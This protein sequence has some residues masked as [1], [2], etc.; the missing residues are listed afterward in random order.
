[1]STSL[2]APES[3]PS[4]AKQANSPKNRLYSL[5]ILRGF[6]M[7]W[8]MGG[9]EFVV[10]FFRLFSPEMAEFFAVQFEHVA[11]NGFHFYD[12]IFP[13]FVFMAG[14]SIPFSVSNRVAK[15]ESK[16]KIHLHILKRVIFLF[17][18]GLIY[19]GLWPLS[20]DNIRIMGVLQRIALCYGIAA[21]LA[22]NFS[23]RIQIFTLFGVLITYWAIMMLVPVPGY[24]AGILTPEGNLSFY[25]DRMI[26]PGQFC[27][28]ET[29]DSEGL[30]S[31]LSASGTAILGSLCGQW[32]KKENPPG[33]RTLGLICIGMVLF[34]L[35]A[36][37]NLVFPINKNLWTGS[38]VFWTGGL[39]FLLMALFYFLIDVL[40]WKKWT[41]FFVVIGSN[42]I[43]VYM[44][45]GLISLYFMIDL[46]PSWGPWGV[47]FWITLSITVKWVIY[48]I[49]YRK[50][51]FLKV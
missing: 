34:S 35:G 41:F 13:L 36:I 26:L 2:S 25:L 45:K 6:D 38:F 5:D 22:V 31:T 8:L 17:G 48:Y 40:G 32:L 7:F 50:N 46:T 27:C 51:W 12:L 49:F 21:I 1:M 14:I 24:G 28:Y 9:T 30:L 3:N 42:S 4:D 47:F 10:A 33:K 11:W 43:L 37:W 18:L 29:G 39:S 19:N 15:G 44:T 20:W 16:V 23:P